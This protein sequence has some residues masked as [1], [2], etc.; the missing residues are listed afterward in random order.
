MVVGHFGYVDDD[1]VAETSDGVDG[2]DIEA[3]GGEAGRDNGSGISVTYS[4]ADR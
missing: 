1:V 3:G 2:L 4:P